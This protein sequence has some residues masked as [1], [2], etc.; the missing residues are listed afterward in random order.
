MSS[1]T[2]VESIKFTQDN[3]DTETYTEKFAEFDKEVIK[4]TAT[5]KGGET[6]VLKEFRHGLGF[7]PACKF[8]PKALDK[9]FADSEN[10]I[11]ACLNEL[12]D[13][14]FWH[15]CGEHYKLYGAFPIYWAYRERCN[16]VDEHLGVQCDGGKL[17]YVNE[18]NETKIKPCPK[19]S[20]KPFIGAGTLIQIE[21]PATREDATIGVPVGKVDVDVNALQFLQE[22]QEARKKRIEFDAAGR[23]FEASKEAIN[24]LQ[25]QA[26]YET[27][28]I[29]L[30]NLSKTLSKSMW[31]VLDTLA[32]LAYPQYHVST[33][34]SLGNQFFLKTV[35]EL[36]AEYKD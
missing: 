12:D 31:F 5:A 16:Y 24:E 8:L 22:E 17:V 4:I 18:A 29:V 13:Y 20:V 33:A 15:T 36:N 28:K 1:E 21:P 6:V 3:P 35:A 34:C 25:V 10:P 14:L 11:T 9:D 26:N 30:E 2:T 23:V 19:C 32:K 7:C 27:R